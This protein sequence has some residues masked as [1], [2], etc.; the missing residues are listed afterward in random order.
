MSGIR[1]L[2]RPLHTVLSACRSLMPLGVISK[3]FHLLVIS[4]SLQAH[5]NTGKKFARKGL[6]QSFFPKA[7]RPFRICP[8]TAGKRQKN[9]EVRPPEREADLTVSP[10]DFAADFFSSHPHH[11]PL[12][13]SSSSQ[14]S[15]GFSLTA[16]ALALSAGSLLWW[17]LNRV[18]PPAPWHTI[19]IFPRGWLMA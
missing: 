8:L 14:A 19:S 15:V 4:R 12:C 7:G 2:D 13:R 6:S 16:K 18:S 1:L 5:C 17:N 9:S 11:S 3:I 10:S